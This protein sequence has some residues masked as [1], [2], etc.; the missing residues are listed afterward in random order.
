MKKV[1]ILLIRSKNIT[2]SGVQN[3]YLSTN[4]NISNKKIMRSILSK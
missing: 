2:L 3:F 4:Q 1:N